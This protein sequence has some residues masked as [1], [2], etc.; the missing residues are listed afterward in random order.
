[1]SAYFFVDSSYDACLCSKSHLESLGE[2]LSLDQGLCLRHNEH[3]DR[4][5]EALPLL[6][7][8]ILSEGNQGTVGIVPT[9]V[10]QQTV[11]LIVRHDSK[12]LASTVN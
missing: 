1:M 7:A 4:V 11:P 3:Q 12:T 6:D 8:F 2:I 5:E 9:R 10:K